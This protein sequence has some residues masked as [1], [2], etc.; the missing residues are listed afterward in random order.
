MT[1][2]TGSGDY[3]AL[4]AAVLAH[5]VTDGW[6]TSGGNWPISKGNVRGVAWSS[7]TVSVTDYLSGGS[8]PFTERII[9]LAIG[10]S[11]ANATANAAIP[12]NCVQIRNMNWSSTEWFIFS[13]PANYNYI[14]VVTRFS[15]GYDADC[16]NHFSFGELDKGGMTYTG[17]AYAASH[18]RRAYMA[19]IASSSTN[20]SQSYDWN[21]GLNS[22]W[23][24]H[25]SG[26]ANTVSSWDRQPSAGINNLVFIVDPTVS[27]LPGAGGW[28]AADT[29]GDQTQVLDTT[30]PDDGGLT[31]VNGARLDTGSYSFGMNF[32]NGAA[33]VQ[34]YSGG[35]TMGALPFILLNGTDQS[36]QGMF[37]GIF[38][39]VRICTLDTY[40]AKDEVTYG[41]DT[42]KLMPL[43]KKTDWSLM[44]QNRIISS[45]NTGYAYKKV[46]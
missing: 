46:A 35:V 20:T 15:N 3:N 14:H 16:F 6:T 27:P 39:G 21:C 9:D 10:T 22:N 2:S 23:R 4:M 32:V 43:L 13:D 42:W 44:Q 29:V 28:Q 25:F 30:A 26:R 36:A 12:A 45:G 37:L 41:S 18:G 17:I 40:A 8:I 19:L 7:R 11:L 38:P 5:A 1:Y 33:N 34:P 31:D 24:G